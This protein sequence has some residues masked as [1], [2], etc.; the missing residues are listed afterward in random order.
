MNYG[1]EPEDIANVKHPAVSLQVHRQPWCQQFDLIV[2]EIEFDSPDPIGHGQVSGKINGRLHN[3]RP[4][5]FRRDHFGN[6]QNAAEL[7]GQPQPAEENCV[8]IASCI[9]N[10]DPRR[11]AARVQ[12][13]CGDHI[14][15]LIE[16]DVRPRQLNQC[17]S[18]FGHAFAYGTG[19]KQLASALCRKA[20]IRIFKNHCN[21]I[22]G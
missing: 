13:A 21:H 18:F 2:F 17:K 1:L 3:R 15:P 4:R 9:F 11:P 5:K 10:N 7:A 14:L 12:P 19:S 20:Q 6:T 16:R 8:K 22:R